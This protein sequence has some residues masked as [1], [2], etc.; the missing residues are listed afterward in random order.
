[1]D[2]DTEPCDC[3][4]CR[5]FRAFEPTLDKFMAENSFTNL[6]A[7]YGLSKVALS[8]ALIH[9]IGLRMYGKATD[10]KKEVEG[11]V[12]ALEMFHPKDTLVVAQLISNMANA[13]LDRLSTL[14]I[15]AAANPM[16][17][18]TPERTM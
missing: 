5:F 10:E 15:H 17:Q 18:D 12:N 8:Q 4:A 1:M 7:A 13:Q 6:D 3:G 14:A 16:N 11:E 2:Q 9:V